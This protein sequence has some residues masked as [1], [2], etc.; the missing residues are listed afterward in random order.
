MR[1]D[2]LLASLGYATRGT[3]PALLRSGAVTVDGEEA[4][5]PARKVLAAA[6][7]VDGAPLDHPDGILVLLHKPAGYVC[8]H[9]S[10][11]G[12][13]VFDLLPERWLRRNPQ[14]TTIGRLDKDTTGA[15]LVTDIPPLVH[16]FISPKRGIDKVYE[17]EL[18]APPRAD[19]VALFAA[20]TLQLDGEPKPCRPAALE[21]GEG[22]RCRV[23]LHEGRYHQVKRMFATCGY[24]VKA[25]HRPRF[26]PY[27]LGDL[28]AGEWRDVDVPAGFAREAT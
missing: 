28:P 26:G 7:L 20:G 21:L 12:A 2:R 5:D 22:T 14:P 25:L 16:A 19:L 18:D 9:D 13:L 10:G 27:E 23:I 8:S 15:L 11:E 6:V 4:R 3:V 1:L 24:L 17:V